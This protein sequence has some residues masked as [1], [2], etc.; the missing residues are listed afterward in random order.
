M[1]PAYFNTL[2][3]TPGQN[4]PLA[5]LQRSPRR[6]DVERD[7]R[8]DG[9]DK[10]NRSQSTL[11]PVKGDHL[12]GIGRPREDYIGTSLRGWVELGESRSVD[13]D[14]CQELSDRGV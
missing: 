6:E 12:I 2:E 11:E 7:H 4:G 14:E 10:M 8:K 9:E 3:G 5:F 1:A 13:R